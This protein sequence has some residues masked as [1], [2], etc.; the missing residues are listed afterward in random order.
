MP[1]QIGFWFFVLKDAIE[2]HVART[3]ALIAAHPDV[4]ARV[5]GEIRGGGALDAQRVEKLQYLGACITETLRLWT[6]VPILLRRATRNF[7]LRDDIFVE[8]GEQL[9]IYAGHYH[10]DPRVFGARADRFSPDKAVADDTPLYVFSAHRQACAGQSLVLFM[11]KATLAS[12]LGR[13]RFELAGPAIDAARIPC[14]YDHF[15]VALRARS[16]A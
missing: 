4:Q 7:A 13:C 9:L 12:L 15:G 14:L 3:L 5:R 10:R 1:T 2:L 11:L 6:P 8:N 16:D